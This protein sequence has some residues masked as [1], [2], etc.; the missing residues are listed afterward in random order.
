M[1]LIDEHPT[2]LL[3]YHLDLDKR[4]TP[5]KIIFENIKNIVNELSNTDN[6][7]TKQEEYE[8]YLIENFLDNY[9]PENIEPK[10][11]VSTTKYEPTKN[12]DNDTINKHKNKKHEKEQTKK[13]EP[14]KEN[15]ELTGKQEEM[16][17]QKG[18][19]VKLYI[20]K[21]TLPSAYP[22]LQDISRVDSDY[23]ITKIATP[24]KMITL[25]NKYKIIAVK[26]HSSFIDK[27]KN[28]KK[29]KPK[30]SFDF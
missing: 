7:I 28:V 2:D 26:Y 11:S 17:E 16:P 5:T 9:I 8:K 21:L 12:T 19:V 25:L 24:D 1:L 23:K 6:L 27:R 18:R 22:T 30:F 4:E 13:V 3:S 15:L 29:P 20:P 14:V 10:K